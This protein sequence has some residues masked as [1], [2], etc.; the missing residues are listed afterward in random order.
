MNP[1]GSGNRRAVPG[2]VDNFNLTTTCFTGAEAPLLPHLLNGLAHGIRIDVLVAFLMKSGVD[3]LVDAL[4]DAVERGVRVRIVC[5]DYL[6][7]TQPSALYA[8][9]SRLGDAA[10]LRFYR[11]NP[12]GQSPDSH[13]PS[14]QHPFG[15]DPSTQSTTDPVPSTHNLSTHIRSFHPKAW[16]LH[17]PEGTALFL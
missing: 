12:S 2:T 8:L 17:D 7:V 16:F 10:S 5:G 3:L 1:S 11:E 4:H 13:A 6:G 9:R 15:H 14:A